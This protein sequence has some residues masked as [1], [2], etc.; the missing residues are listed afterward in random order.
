MHVISKQPVACTGVDPA[1]LALRVRDL[2]DEDHERSDEVE[3]LDC[4]A[5]EDD[6]DRRVNASH[7]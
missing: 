5:R 2:R 6:G 1:H 3:E 4:A 7:G